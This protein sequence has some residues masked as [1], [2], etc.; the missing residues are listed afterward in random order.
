MLN[1]IDLKNCKKG[2]SLLELVIACAI[3]AVVLTISTNSLANLYVKFLIKNLA[4]NL[5]LTMRKSYLRSIYT[6]TD[7][8]LKPI[9][10]TDIDKSWNN[11]WVAFVDSNS[12]NHLDENEEIIDKFKNSNDNISINH[13]KTNIECII[14]RP[15]GLTRQCKANLG[16]LNNGTI[17]FTSKQALQHNSCANSINLVFFRN[18]SRLCIATKFTNDSCVCTK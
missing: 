5:S 17:Y 10:S 14:F 16:L 15:N 6:H 1:Y 8:T 13:L 11:G 9:A 2:F 3:V 4:T 18:K 7:I 12:N